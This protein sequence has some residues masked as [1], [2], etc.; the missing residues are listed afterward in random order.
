MYML[1]AY[2]SPRSG[3]HCGLQC[4]QMPNLA[5][6][7]HAGHSYASSDAQYGRNGPVGTSPAKNGDWLPARA[8]AAASRPPAMK[9]RRFITASPPKTSNHVPSVSGTKTNSISPP[10]ISIGLGILNDVCIGKFARV[11]Q[12]DGISGE[13][14]VVRERELGAGVQ[15]SVAI[16]ELRHSGLRLRQHQVPVSPGIRKTCLDAAFLIIPDCRIGVLREPLQSVMRCNRLRRI[17]V[18]GIAVRVGIAELGA[19]TAEYPRQPAE[20]RA[21]TQFDA[22]D[23]GALAI[24]RLVDNKRHLIDHLGRDT[25]GDERIDGLVKCRCRGNRVAVEIRLQAELELRGPE[26]QQVGIAPGDAFIAWIAGN[27]L[28]RRQIG[29]C[30]T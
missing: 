17:D 10:G 26:R 24:Y 23:G 22:L 25:A 3:T 21:V 30:W 5:S 2:Q 15:L 14:D 13:N 20:Y 19:E 28:S 4:A 9:S 16:A 12:I 27:G 6:R 7:N 8:A 29:E 1:R 18:T 11:R